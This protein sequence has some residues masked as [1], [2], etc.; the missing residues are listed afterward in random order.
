MTGGIQI[1]QLQ[2][3]EQMRRILMRFTNFNKNDLEKLLRQ[4]IFLPDGTTRPLSFFC[5]V[6]VIPG[7][8][9]QK[10]EDLK[11]NIILT[12][13]L[14]GRDL[15]STIQEI[16]T[17]FKQQLALPQ[18]YSIG[19]GGAYAQQQQS[20]KELLLILG[21]AT[22]LVFGV[23]LFLFKEWMISFVILF[24]S[25]AGICGCILALYFTGIPMNVSS[26]TGIIM[27][28]GIIAENAIF[29]VYQFKTNLRSQGNVGTAVNYAIAQRLRPKLM[30]AIGAI[31]ALTPLALGIGLG[32]QMQQPLA[33]AVIG[34]FI[35][36]L[37]LLPVVLPSF[38]LLI[39]K[40]AGENANP[41][42]QTGS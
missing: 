42:M 38:M 4:F 14:N 26:Y 21:M 6:Q 24:I 37:P 33:V 39:Y 2:D 10:R 8:M 20:F 34:G 31:L 9:D 17:R 28:V 25:V 23:L 41:V 1:G 13:R 35:A 36:G 32:A 22:L 12:A 29:T 40:K 27:I 3:G 5:H 15:G 30:T 7:E 16:Q 18:G 19:Y 11:S